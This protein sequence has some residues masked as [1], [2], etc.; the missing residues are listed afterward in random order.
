MVLGGNNSVHRQPFESFVNDFL[1]SGKE[2]VLVFRMME[3]DDDDERVTN[4]RSKTT[5]VEQIK[6][7]C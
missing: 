1:R 2:T 3:N 7:C 6:P 5:A 4:M